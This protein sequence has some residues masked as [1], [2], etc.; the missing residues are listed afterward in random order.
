MTPADLEAIL[1]R[2]V[3]E[4]ATEVV[5]EE[6]DRATSSG[7]A[8][9][10]GAPGGCDFCKLDRASAR[11]LIVGAHNAAICNECIAAAVQHVIGHTPPEIA[12]LPA[13][14]PSDLLDQRFVRSR[15]VDR[16]GGLVY[17][18]ALI[19]DIDIRR[20]K[21]GYTTRPIELRLETFRTTNP[22]AS[23]LGMW[24]A[25]SDGEA[26]AHGA[27]SG[28]LGNAEVF[29]VADVVAAVVA[30]DEELRRHWP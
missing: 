22:T 1:R 11:K 19:P 13:T 4:V 9:I 16:H 24:A 5:R 28:R 21:V 23:L 20:I 26:V 12:A 7:P 15:D 29:H 18:V 30:I 10:H 17:A 14:L 3:R 2:V 25:P 6:L 8:T 27:V